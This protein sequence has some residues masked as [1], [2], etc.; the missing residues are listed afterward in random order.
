MK[1][2]IV[3][4]AKAFVG[5]SQARNRYTFF[6]KISK[7]EGFEQ[8]AEIFLLTADN[9]REHASWFYKM[10]LELKTKESIVENI[11]IEAE[12][13]CILSTT[14]E[15]LK[16]AI[17]GET[18]E[19]TSLYPSFAETAIQEGFP[20]I[21]SRIQAISEAEKHHAQRYALILSQLEK[22]SIFKKDQEVIWICRE[23]GYPHFGFEPPLQCPSC[24]HEKGFY[25]LKCETY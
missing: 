5:E 17:T 24:G 3:N 1:Q 25:Q 12:V 16:A 18:E 23:C 6:S 7:K 10:L 4:L 14:M 11:K 8:I 15:N 19:Y 13:P 22:N 21:A 2:T 9:E 20:E